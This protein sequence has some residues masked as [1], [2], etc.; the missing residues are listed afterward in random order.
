MLALNLAVYAAFIGM[1]FITMLLYAPGK[2]ASFSATLT[3]GVVPLTTMALWANM[4]RFLYCI[5]T[6]QPA[7]MVK[8]LAPLTAPL[9]FRPPPAVPW[10]ASTTMVAVLVLALLVT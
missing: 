9:K 3:G 10:L 6:F 5:T 7:G 1:P 4:P 2:A 8:L